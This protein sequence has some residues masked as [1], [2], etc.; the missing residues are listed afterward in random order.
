LERRKLQYKSSVISY[1]KLG[2][3]PETVLC[4]HGYAED[5]SSFSFLEISTSTRLTLLCIDLPFHGET[6]W[7]EDELFKVQDL[8]TIIQLI[9]KQQG[10]EAR[11]FTIAGFS[12]GGRVA[13]S[14]YEHMP[15]GI[16]RMILLAPDGLKLNF[17]YW[18]AT[19]TW[20]GRNLFS[21]TMKNPA[22]FFGLLTI[23]YKLR[24]VNA[25]V[26][27]FVRHYVDSRDARL[28]LYSRWIVLRH[29]RPDIKKIKHHI[30][31][32]KTNVNIVYGK[33][34]RIILPIR[35]EKFKKGIE[36]HCSISVIRSGHQVLHESHLEEIVP[37]FLLKGC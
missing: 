9:F 27:K 4:F 15:A 26:F 24:F 12:L 16:N 30:N 32:N 1:L 10:T 13:L 8:E 14:L 5:A 22:W 28:E 23:L 29:L 33:H 18:L 31:S 21:F 36:E 17:W 37:V 7:K 20:F 19:Q 3:G 11:K 34:D 35:G 6:E 2:H 25:S